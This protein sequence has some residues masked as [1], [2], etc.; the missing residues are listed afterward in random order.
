MKLTQPFR[1]FSNKVFG[2][3]VDGT[4]KSMTKTTVT[5]QA[6]F[7][8]HYWNETRSRNLNVF[9]PNKPAETQEISLESLLN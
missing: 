4:I 7:Q 3:W 2:V 8:G 6:Y 1:F 5:I 9:L